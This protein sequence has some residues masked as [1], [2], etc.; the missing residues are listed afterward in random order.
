MYILENKNALKDLIDQDLNHF[1]I[2]ISPLRTFSVKFIL[3]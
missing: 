3:E 2:K 1:S